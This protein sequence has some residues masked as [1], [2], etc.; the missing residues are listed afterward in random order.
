MKLSS[1]YITEV[2]IKIQMMDLI[3]PPNV[4]GKFVQLIKPFLNFHDIY[5]SSSNVQESAIKPPLIGITNLKNESLPLV[6]LEFKGFRLM[7]PVST[8]ILQ[9]QQHDLLMLQV[10]YLPSI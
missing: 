10:K 8:K 6:Y 3:L 5:Q 1:S 9:G 4:L 7:L 2:D